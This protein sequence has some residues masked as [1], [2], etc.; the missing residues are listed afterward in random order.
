[1]IQDYFLIDQPATSFPLAIFAGAIIGIGIGLAMYKGG[2]KM[3]LQVFLIASS[4]FLYLVAAG[5]M[6]KGVWFFELERF[7]EKCGQDTSETG[8]GPGSY[9]VSTAL[10]HVN[11][12]NGLTDGGWMLFNA[13]LGWSN[14]G[15]YGSVSSYIIFWLAVVV[16]LRI[17]LKWEKYGYN[18]ILPISWQL[19]SIRKRIMADR[20]LYQEYADLKSGAN[21]C[22]CDMTLGANISSSGE[23]KALHGSDNDGSI[24]LIPSTA[25][26]D[27]TDALLV[28][29]Q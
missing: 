7:V 25:D 20:L 14:T 3:S 5:L 16:Y 6:S 9:D 2:N 4:C 28:D 10:W 27:E 24:P 17:R 12:C 8:S 11:C 1:M 13:L 22:N 18:S 29:G 23:G 21:A 26:S 19:K 15:T